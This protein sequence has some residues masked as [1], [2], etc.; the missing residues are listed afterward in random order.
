M[1]TGRG[2]FKLLW[3]ESGERETLRV[4]FEGEKKGETWNFMDI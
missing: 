3:G 2:S 1:S 4:G